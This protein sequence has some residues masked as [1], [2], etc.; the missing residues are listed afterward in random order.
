[1]LIPQVLIVDKDPAAARVLLEVFARRA[2]RGIVADSPS[3]DRCTNVEM[4][5]YALDAGISPVSHVEIIRRL[6]MASPEL[7]VIAMLGADSGEL[8][9][10]AMKAGCAEILTKPLQRASITRV[11]DAFLPNHEVPAV[12]ASASDTGRFQIVGRSPQMRAAI[13]IARKAARTSIPVMICGESGTGK[14]LLAS[15]IH[16]ASLRSDGPYI[17]LNCA[18]ISDS[19]L[20][21]ELFG[22]EKGAFTGAYTRRK[23]RFERAHGGTLLLDEITE[24]PLRFQAELLRVIEQQ[25]FERVGGDESISVNVRIVSTTN[26]DIMAEVRKGN[27]R[28]DLFYRLGGVRLRIA[29]L[30]ERAEDMAALVWHFINL[31]SREVGRQINAVDPLTIDM[32]ASYSWPGNVRQ[33][34]SVIRTAMVMGSGQTLS[35]ADIGL[36]MDDL[37]NEPVIS[38]SANHL[39]GRAL[40]EIEQKAIIA[41][42]NQ[43]RGN[44]ARAAK[45]LGISD[46]TLREKLKKYRQQGLL[47]LTA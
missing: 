34:R 35:P 26:K 21:S 6:R 13:E 2:I 1:M 3:A 16:S 17:R 25:D 19:L 36:V 22:H 12:A 20:E 43:T 23:G 4:V 38:E 11:L 30:R 24:T 29:P 9:F 27:F 28:E 14:E 47:Q 46:R 7:A 42:L 44:Q 10:A 15:L 39:A 8:A 37:K 32:L 18:A 5:F 33:L 40:Q 45:T 31:H 41:T